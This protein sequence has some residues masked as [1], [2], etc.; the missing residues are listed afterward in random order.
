MATLGLSPLA[1]RL[2]REPSTDSVLV[3]AAFGDVETLKV[4]VKER[5]LRNED[6]ETICVEV[7]RPSRLELDD[8]GSAV[9][10]ATLAAAGDHL[11]FL[12][13]W[14]S[15]KYPF[16]FGEALQEALFCAA[17][18]TLAYLLRHG[19]FKGNERDA[20]LLSVAMLSHHERNVPRTRLTECFRLIHEHFGMQF[21]PCVARRATMSSH[22]L[23][24]PCHCL[25]RRLRRRV[26]D[27]A[28]FDGPRP[29]VGYPQPGLAIPFG[30]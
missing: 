18:R 17:P 10:A 23:L 9:H 14:I 25:P 28:R 3:A 29:D 13:Y 15:Q 20:Y 7:D 2:F 5:R 12:Q 30:F 21:S 6:L 27:F 26:R 8:G 16:H 11:D 22:M 24:R 1:H 4:V 19:N